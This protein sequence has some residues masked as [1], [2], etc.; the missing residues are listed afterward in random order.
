MKYRI[1][2]FSNPKEAIRNTGHKLVDY[3]VDNPLD[4]AAYV[5]GDLVLPGI[6]AKKA[7]KKWTGKKGKIAAGV[8]TGYAMSPVGVTA[9]GIAYKNKLKKKKN[10]GIS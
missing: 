8:L 1:K 6:L 5:A 7:V 10:N 9:A 3:A 4:T 2:R